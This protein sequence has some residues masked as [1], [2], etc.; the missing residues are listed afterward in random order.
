MGGCPHG[1]EGK[2]RRRQFTPEFKR[3]AVELV[4]ATGRPVA[5]IAAELGIYDS[6]LGNWVKQAEIDHG[7]REGL[8]SD[9]KA[10]LRELEAEN[11]KLRMER[12]LRKRTVAFWVKETSTPC[13]GTTAWTTAWML[14][15]A[16]GFPVGAACGAA[17]VSTSAYYAWTANHAQ[18]PSPAE[19]QQA[20][21]IAQIRTI[22]ADSDGVYGSPRVTAGHRGSPRSCAAAAGGCTANACKRIERLMAVHG[23]AATAPTPAMPY[24]ARRE[25]PARA[26]PTRTY[27]A[28]SSILTSP[29]WPGAAT[30]P[31]SR[32][33]PDRRRLAVPGLYLAS[34][35]DLASR[36]LLGWSM[37]D[38]HDASWSPTRSTLPSPPGQIHDARHDLPHRP[39]RR[40]HL[41]DLRQR[42]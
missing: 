31:T 27:W 11:A 2:R 34:V 24:Q 35:L 25:H 21:L 30:S 33:R 29:T 1:R 14:E 22:H 39:R 38:R 37:G 41:C 15:R 5:H 42:L 9:D 7:E 17:D 40:I 8:T 19:Q 6:T 13:A 23:L 16:A 26:G 28:D 32:L 10:R 3:D 36:H 20:E 12:D 18:K 4:P